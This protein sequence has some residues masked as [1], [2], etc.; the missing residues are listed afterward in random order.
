M[1]PYVTANV[2]RSQRSLTAQLRTGIHPL[3]LEVGRFKNIQ[4]EN[5]L[6]E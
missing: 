1:I 6:C 5:R 2:S 4:E 3:T